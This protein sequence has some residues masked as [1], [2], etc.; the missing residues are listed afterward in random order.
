MVN[1]YQS[2]NTQINY[3]SD[4]SSK[5]NVKAVL[6]YLNYAGD[7]TIPERASDH[8]RDAIRCALALMT[9]VQE[10]LMACQDVNER[11]GRPCI[12]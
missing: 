1:A 11:Q 8:D 10:R 6:A 2:T 5:E 9:S 3:A 4:L 12:F 7:P